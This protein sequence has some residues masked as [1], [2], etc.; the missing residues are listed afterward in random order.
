MTAKPWRLGT[1]MRAAAKIFERSPTAPAPEEPAKFSGEP[2]RASEAPNM[3]DALTGLVTRSHFERAALAALAWRRNRGEWSGLLRIELAG[4]AE[5]NE[6][7]GHAAGDEILRLA[8][9]RL[10]GALGDGALITRLGG[11]G[12]AALTKAANR[13]GSARVAANVVTD[14]NAPFN[15]ESGDLRISAAVGF[16]VAPADGEDFA[17]LMRR[18]E[19]ARLRARQEDGAGWRAYE[20]GLDNAA[21]ARRDLQGALGEARA[22]RRLRLHYQP[23]VELTSGRIQGFEALLRWNHP[24]LG[25]IGAQDFVPLAEETGLIGSIG[26]WAL[27]EACREAAR[28]PHDIRVAVNVSPIQ[29]RMGA[30]PEEVARALAASGLPAHRLELELTEGVLIGDRDFARREMER[31][32][33]LGVLVALDDFG[34]GFASFGYLSSLPFKRLKIDQS[35]VREMTVRPNTA[36]VI[37]SIAALA[38]DLG[39]SLVV[40]G[41]DAPEQRDWLIANGFTE[42]QG[43]LF[44]RGLEAEAVMERIAAQASADAAA[45]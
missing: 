4:L 18:A 15:F 2:G 43:Y 5:I 20:A 41:V 7:F 24:T 14:I 37:K 6:T 36:V 31:L 40:E 38:G 12:F 44:G 42:A 30:L 25:L 23:I 28:W 32:A 22:Q 9:Q 10:K 45:A 11:A 17:V 19:F 29:L 21:A 1:A 16:A 39:L 8:A 3:T 13:S 33:E 35:F 34:A 27:E 26:L